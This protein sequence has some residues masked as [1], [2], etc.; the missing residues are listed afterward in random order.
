MKLQAKLLFGFVPAIVMIVLGLAWVVFTQL[1]ANS[2]QDLL[3]QMELVVGQTRAQ[4]DSFISTALANASLFANSTIVERYIRVEDEAER[5][6]LMQPAVLDLFATYRQAYPAYLEIQLLLP[7]GYEDTRLARPGTPNATDEEAETPF[8]KALKV[9]TGRTHTAFLSNPDDGQPVFKFGQSIL[10]LDRSADPALARQILHG[11]LVVT[12]E[13]SFL[14]RQV[15][16]ARIGRTGYLFIIDSK[17]TIVEHADQALVGSHVKAADDLIDLADQSASGEAELKGPRLSSF[18]GIPAIVRSTK[19]HDNLF[20][21]SVLPEYE[22]QTVSRQLAWAVAGVTLVTICLATSFFWVLLRTLVLSPLKSLQGTAIAIGNG[23]H[24]P[25]LQG[26]V[27]RNDEIGELES[28]FHDMNTKLSHSMTQL[29]SS[30]GRIHELAFKDSLTGLPN[31]RQFLE[32]LESAIINSKARRTQLTIL[33]LDLDGFKKVN[34]L[35]GHDAGDD[36]LLVIAERLRNCFRVPVT[37][38]SESLGHRETDLSLID[39]ACIARLGGD[40][41]I[42]LI[43]GVGNC[44]EVTI[45]TA[46]AATASRVLQALAQPIDVLDQRFTVGSSIGISIYPY[47]AIDPAGLLKCADTAMYAVK[48]ATKNGWQLYDESMR[49]VVEQQV[50]LENDLRH[51]LERD[52]FHLVYQPQICT[53]TGQ[54]VGVE[55]LLRWQHPEHGLISPADFIPMAEQTGLIDELGSRVINESCRQWKEWSVLGIAPDWVAVNVSPKQFGRQDLAGVVEAAL[56]N[57]GVPYRALEIEIT[58]SCMMEAPTAVVD[59]LHYLRQQGVRIALDDFGTGHSSLS[60]LASLP[61]DTLKIDR[62]FVTD[63]HSDDDKRSVMMAVLH[64]ARN[65]GLSTV[66]EGVECKE[67]QDFLEA[68]ECDV[69]QGY[70]LSRPLSA[71]AVTQWLTASRTLPLKRAS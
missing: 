39:E 42:V 5:F 59:T 66:A 57:H 30:Y 21:V 25:E 63:V 11:Y 41:F 71:S 43:P 60:M 23:D 49:L 34:D 48:H 68:H 64:L 16:E 27:N 1:R 70:F 36:L 7:D 50:R 44:D 38:S 55:A 62:S 65:L 32:S 54:A 26:A 33:F 56:Q 40:E 14:A 15:A 19:L 22:L 45:A 29:Q 9:A 69:L 3:R 17:G 8:F 20:L 35:L 13:P 24:H 51:A 12:A 2:E 28:A 47:H 67:E 53:Q 4:T 58:E 46:A 10:L 52:E 61:I 37:H 31:R 6:E 18:G